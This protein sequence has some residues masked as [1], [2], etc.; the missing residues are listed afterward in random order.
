VRSP[1]QAELHQLERV[2]GGGA[3]A[4]GSA[5]LQV[6]AVQLEEWRVGSDARVDRVGETGDPDGGGAG[7]EWDP[8][9]RLHFGR[10]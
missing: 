1:P 6:G 7:A 10:S 3:G 9:G 8:E 4:T 5:V 2:L